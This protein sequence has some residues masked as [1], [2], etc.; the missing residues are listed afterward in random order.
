MIK[1]YLLPKV[2]Y[3]HAYRCKAFLFSDLVIHVSV[4][5]VDGR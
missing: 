3:T 2:N 5:R 4:N 1:Y